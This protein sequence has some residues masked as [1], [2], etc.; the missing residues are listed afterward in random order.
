MN[1]VKVHTLV[2]KT[3]PPVDFSFLCRVLL[4]VHTPESYKLEFHHGSS[5]R[6]SKCWDA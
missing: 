1:M 4:L 6:V 5:R 2:L 3:F